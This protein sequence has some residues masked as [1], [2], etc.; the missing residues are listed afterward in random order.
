MGVFVSVEIGVDEEKTVAVSVGKRVWVG[1]AIR[2]SEGYG[3]GVQGGSITIVG[4]GGVMSV[5]P[6][7]AIVRRVKNDTKAKDFL[8]PIEG[9]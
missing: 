6:P 5:N 7:Q 3:L 9:G 4:V 1:R 2:V 8:K